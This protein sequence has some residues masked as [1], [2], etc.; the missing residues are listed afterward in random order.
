MGLLSTWLRDPARENKSGRTNYS[1]YFVTTTSGALDAT[2]TDSPGFTLTKVAAT[3][4]RY[5]VQL[6]DQAGVAV[7]VSPTP[8][9]K[10]TPGILAF[11]ATVIPTAGLTAIKGCSAYIRAGVATLATNGTFIVQFYQVSG[12]DAEVDDGAAMLIE[13]SIKRSSAVP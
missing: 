13:F 7:V 5:T 8:N 9:S 3:A 11:R 12:A 4:G 10:A 2:K 6:T 1:G